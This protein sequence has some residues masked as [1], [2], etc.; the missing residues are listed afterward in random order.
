MVHEIADG[1]PGGE[2]RDSAG[3]VDVIM[4]ENHKVDLR[5][6]RL[7]YDSHDSIRVARARPPGIDQQGFLQGYL[8]AILA[9]GYLDAGLMP[10]SDILTGPGVV[11]K[12]NLDAV[13]EGAKSGMR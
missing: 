2:F 10:G 4:R 3:M 12:S 7:L 1:N 13:I 11:N 6:P 5:N 8:P 9:R